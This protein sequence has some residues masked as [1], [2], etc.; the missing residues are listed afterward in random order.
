MQANMNTCG[1][2][3]ESWAGFSFFLKKKKNTAL[4]SIED[5]IRP[6]NFMKVVEG[7]KN[8]AGYNSETNTYRRPSLA[9]KI[10]HGLVKISLLVESRA[11]VQSN[12]TAAKEARMFRRIY[13]T[14]WNE[15]ISAASL[16]TLQESKW[17]TPQL[18]PFKSDVQ[19]LHFQKQVYSNCQQEHH[20]RHGK[21]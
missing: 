9:L 6:A 4:K 16:R 7:E 3:W 14:R 2:K 10:G 5:H 11:N 8:V 1:R 13:E 21:N 17:N 20:L 19:K 18:L 15:M 12:F